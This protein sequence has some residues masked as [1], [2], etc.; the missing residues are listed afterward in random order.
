MYNS[1]VRG[2]EGREDQGKAMKGCEILCERRESSIRGFVRA[3]K[4]CERLGGLIVVKGFWQ[5]NYEER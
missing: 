5:R 3:V 1:A 4:D 2:C